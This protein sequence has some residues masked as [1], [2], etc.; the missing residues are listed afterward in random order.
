MKSDPD[1][2]LSVNMGSLKNLNSTNV[3]DP[4][5]DCEISDNSYILDFIEKN[6]TNNT[7]NLSKCA[8]RRLDHQQSN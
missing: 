2:T 1:F 8:K 3:E 5:K 4:K 6:E 7:K